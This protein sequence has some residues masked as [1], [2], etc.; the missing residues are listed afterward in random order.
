MKLR[1]K[2]LIH[3]SALSS[4]GSVEQA[5]IPLLF[6]FEERLQPHNK[7]IRVVYIEHY[8]TKVAWENKV[9]GIDRD[10]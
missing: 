5:L 1:S 4:Q 9:L 7:G 3:R 10:K 6:S 8:A 2:T